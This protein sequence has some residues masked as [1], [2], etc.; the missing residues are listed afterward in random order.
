MHDF[1]LRFLQ[2][3]YE[4]STCKQLRGD[5]NI[6]EICLSCCNYAY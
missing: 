5:R 2:K 4:I 1:P 3:L 6:T